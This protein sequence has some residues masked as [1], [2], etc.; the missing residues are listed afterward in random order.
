MKKNVMVALVFCMVTFFAKSEEIFVYGWA[1]TIPAS[2]I[3]NFT[4]ETGIKVNFTTFE[5]NETMYAKIKLLSKQPSY[6]VIFP[7]NY[8]IEKLVNE[9]L[10]EELDHS[11]ISNIKY[12]DENVMNLSCDPKNKFSIPYFLYLTGITYNKKFIKEK[13]TSWND[14]YSSKYKGRLALPDDIREVF[15]L[16]LILLGHNVNSKNELEI[17]EAY[18]KVRHLLPNVRLFFS[19][20]V[21]TD[22]L[23]EEVVIAMNWNTNS[24]Q[25]TLLDDNIEFIYPKEGAIL[26]IDNMSIL[27]TSKNKINAHKF[28]NFLHRPEIA[29]KIIEELKLSV[30]NDQAKKMLPKDIRE[31]KTMFPDKALIEKSLI[32]NDIGDSIDVYNM[33]WD[34]LKVEN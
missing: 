10:L 20:L 7:S 14:L 23:S 24:F 22:L 21:Q 9:K 5:N 17:K 25:A 8:F 12:I 16:G 26:S 19:D 6:D 31:N 32:N 2:V 28:I 15:S 1:E 4:D 11:Q 30:V 29:K 33:Y 27:K 34:M 3:K 13:I 18:D